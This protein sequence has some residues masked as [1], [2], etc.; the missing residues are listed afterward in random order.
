MVYWKTPGIRVDLCP[1]C[2]GYQ[3]SHHLKTKDANKKA[4][5]KLKEKKLAE[6]SSPGED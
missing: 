6:K 2:R 1:Y 3:S 4:Y 5:Q